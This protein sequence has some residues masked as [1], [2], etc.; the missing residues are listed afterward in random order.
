MKTTRED[1][2]RLVVFELNMET[3]LYAHF[4]LNGVVGVWRH[5]V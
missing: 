3:I 2:L 1:E 5:S 4:H